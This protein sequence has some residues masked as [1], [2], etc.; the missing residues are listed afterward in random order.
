MVE[1]ER[2]AT[3]EVSVHCFTLDGVHVMRGVWTE[4]ASGS[5]RNPRHVQPMV[6]TTYD[7][8]GC[9]SDQGILRTQFCN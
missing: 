4:P 1:R 7:A 3:L 2:A 8:M 5:G 9:G 6:D